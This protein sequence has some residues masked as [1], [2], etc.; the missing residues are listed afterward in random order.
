MTTL[1]KRTN[2]FDPPAD[3]PKEPPRL[4]EPPKPT[5]PPHL[6]IDTLGPKVGFNRALLDKPEGR[7]QLS[8]EVA[9]VRQHFEGKEAPV[10]VDRKAKISW[11]VALIDELG[12]IGV[13]AVKVKTETRKE[14]PAEITFLPPAKASSAPCSPV[15]MVL[16]DRGTAVWKIVRGHGDETGSRVCRTGSFDD[17]GNARAHRQRLLGIERDFRVRRRGDRMGAGLRPGWIGENSRGP[18][19]RQRR[20][21]AGN[22]GPR[23][24]SRRQQLTSHSGQIVHASAGAAGYSRAA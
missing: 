14:F 2:P 19:V 7:A 18:E 3:K 12:K 11:V 10:I 21:L 24:Q 15:A 16:E 6:T 13:T 5:G 9:A 4:T 8:Q 23:P 22:A 1:P 17:P 20:A